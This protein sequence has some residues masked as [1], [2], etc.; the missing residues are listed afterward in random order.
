ME[1]PCGYIG[2]DFAKREVNESDAVFSCGQAEI[3]ICPDCGKEIAETR[4]EA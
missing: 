1:C 4:E 2:D 3:W